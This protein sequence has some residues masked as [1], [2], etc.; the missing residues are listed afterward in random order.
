M[1]GTT[2]LTLLP[3]L[4]S[5]GLD[6]LTCRK[7]WFCLLARQKCSWNDGRAHPWIWK[8]AICPQELKEGFY[9]L[10]LVQHRWITRSAQHAQKHVGVVLCWPAEHSAAIP[11]ASGHLG[12]QTA[13]LGCSH[14]RDREPRQSLKNWADS[15]APRLWMCAGLFIQSKLTRLLS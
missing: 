2:Q 8:G 5:P 6:A 15:S 11:S 7:A 4:E 1:A 9:K 13:W 12:K 14:F 10:L 3:L